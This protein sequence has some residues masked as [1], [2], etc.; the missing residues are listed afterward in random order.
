MARVLITGGSGL[1]GRHLTPLLLRQGH[2]VAHLT[3]NP[4]YR[5]GDIKSFRW[6]VGQQAIDPAAI[7]WAEHIIHLAGESVGQ[8][9]TK[10]VKNRILHS[11]IASTELLR[12][13]LAATRHHLQSFI[14]ASALGFYGDNTGNTLLTE[15][16]PRGEGFLAD[17]VYAWEAAVDRT[18]P[19]A[20]RVVKIRIGVVLAKEGGA[21]PKML[22][23]V[24]WGV[25]AALGSGRQWLSWL[26]VEDLCR[27][28]LLALTQPLQG[29]YNG[30]GPNP[31]TNKDFTQKLAKQVKRPLFLPPVPSFALRLLLGEMA[32]LALGGNR[33]Q[34]AALIEEGF[35]F[36]YAGLEPALANLL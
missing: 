17:V 24:T 18:A 20:D 16:S 2:E 12:N 5:P 14:S 25:G 27:I 7:P 4:H 28:F 1:I 13:Q 23:P 33:A 11:R 30:V 22:A 26:H 29:V 10:G 8:R 6:D 21:L 31:V 32:V 35:T 19:H 3:R 36:T 15:A 34:P 9:W